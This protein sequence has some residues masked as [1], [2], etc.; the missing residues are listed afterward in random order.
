MTGPVVDKRISYTAADTIP[1][2]LILDK[3]LL[4]STR[5]GIILPVHIQFMPT[6]KCNLNC[7]FCSCSMRDKELA[8]DF[9]DAKRIIDICAGLGTKAVTITGGGEPL[10]YPYFD[11]LV[12]YF[13]S[14]NIQIGLVTNGLLLHKAKAD[15]L[16]KMTWCR[17]SSG[18]DRAFSRQ[19]SNSLHKAVSM[20]K[21][22][23]WAFSHVASSR[24]NMETIRRMILFAN[25]H[26]F[27]HIRIVSD[28]FNP[29]EIA[30]D[31]IKENLNGIDDSLVIYQG[32][33]EYTTGGDC[34][35]GYLKPVI[36]PDLKV[37]ACC[38]VQYASVIPARDMHM[39]FSLGNAYDL[40]EIIGKSRTPFSGE[41]CAKCYYDNYNQILSSMLKDIRHR[42]FV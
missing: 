9:E 7:P 17:I 6:N 32:R 39:D 8:M 28:L 19:Y 20:A 30:L 26:N 5:K 35:I 14:R 3:E 1:I 15:T 24:P 18:D 42:E 21:N 25:E 2:K 11:E 34:Y 36:A 41:K 13:I 38:G 27:T 37:Y 33:K 40:A 23:D 16:Q 29:E 31:A 12:N 4:E 22:V 10:C